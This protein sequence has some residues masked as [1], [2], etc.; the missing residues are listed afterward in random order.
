LSPDHLRHR[1]WAGEEKK[2]ADSLD[3]LEHLYY[4]GKG[5]LFKEEIIDGETCTSLTW[6]MLTYCSLKKLQPRAGR[7]HWDWRDTI[8][9]KMENMF[10]AL[11]NLASPCS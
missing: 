10:V 3:L 4:T 11:S 7:Q 2:R 5:S 6:R 1:K 8:S 9:R